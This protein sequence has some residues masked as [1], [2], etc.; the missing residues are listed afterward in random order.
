MF[1]IASEEQY[2]DGQIIF[3]EDSSGDWVYVI[4]S[5]SVE[6]SRTIQGQKFVLA[7]L[8]EGEAFGELSFL[9]GI[10]RSAT[11]KAVGETN[12]G[13]IDRNAMDQEFNKLSSDFRAIIVAAVRRFKNM[14][15]R[16]CD[17]ST[18]KEE[19]LLKTLSLN[20]KDR[21]SFIKAY[22]QDISN[23]GLFIKAKNPLKQGEQFMLNLQLPDLPEPM[24]IK[25]Q[26]AW[27]KQDEGTAD[28]HP[29]GMGVKFIEM[30]DKDSKTLKKYIKSIS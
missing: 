17:F 4:L 7:E 20:Y 30:S 6:I 16:A 24:K 13:I 5:G 9:G 10:K 8:K 18:R 1:T 15:D 26:V 14:M 12:L 19:R 29:P 3:K 25:C 27:T 11:A 22:T 2:Q 28:E 21:K 23:G